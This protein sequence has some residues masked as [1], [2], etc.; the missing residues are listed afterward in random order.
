M[1]FLSYL[2]ITTVRVE[3]SNYPLLSSLLLKSNS[4]I[5]T[6]KAPHK[7]VVV[8]V[9]LALKTKLNKLSRTR[10]LKHDFFGVFTNTIYKPHIISIFLLL[11]K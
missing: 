3:V 5:L 4:P 10:K 11:E 7:I 9:K 6:T 1:N 2:S 8:I